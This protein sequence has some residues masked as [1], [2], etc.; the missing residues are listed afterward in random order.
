M[1][2]IRIGFIGCGRHATANLYPAVRLAGG[3]IVAVCARHLDRAQTTAKL[4]GAERAYDSVAHLLR[5]DLDAV[6][7][8][9]P[10]AEQAAVVADVLRAGRHVFVEKPLGLNAREAGEI[11]E[12][13]AKAGAFV[14]VGFMKRF[15]P[16]YQEMRRVA[17]THDFGDMLSLHG[18]FAIGSRPGW[19]DAWFLRTGG[20]HY[21]DLC[22]YLFGE[23]SDVQ[24]ARNS[25]GAQVTQLVTLRFEHNRIGG[26]FFGGVP[27]WARHHE[28]LTITGVNGFVRVENMVRVVSHLNRP[29]ASGPPRWQVLDEEDRVLSS[30]HTGASG[31]SQPLY[32]NG[33]VGEVAHFFDCV[34]TRTPPQPSAADNV[35]TMTLCDRILRALGATS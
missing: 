8:A 28:E 23:V 18:M 25:R 7:V 1:N 27:A 26:L 31:G 11:A 12:L 34:R 10:E 9:T 16:A 15:A 17:Q 14:M 5:E 21:V 13:A 19:E 29:T 22:R 20:I 35:L 33:Y 24:G 30:V 6:F 4:F 3:Q 2:S 32:L